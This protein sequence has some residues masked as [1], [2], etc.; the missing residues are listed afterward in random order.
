MAFFI[1]DPLVVY[2]MVVPEED[3]VKAGAL[4][5]NGSRRILLIVWR[6][7]AAILSRMEKTEDKVWAFNIL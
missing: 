1:G 2:L 3:D 7:D 5:G 4:T 6:Y